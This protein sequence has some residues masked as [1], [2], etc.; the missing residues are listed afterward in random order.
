MSI[1][2]GT[3][4]SPPINPVQDVLQELETEVQDI[5][6]GFE[7]R[8]R[9]LRRAGARVFGQMAPDSDDEEAEEEGVDAEE[10]AL[11]RHPDMAH[12]LPV[13][14]DEAHPDAVPAADVPLVGRG[15]G[16]VEEAFR[17]AEAVLS[18]ESR[19]AAAMEIAAEAEAEAATVKPAHAEL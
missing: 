13:P 16:E 2:N 14:G 18:P 12:I 11:L 5:V 15:K 4:P 6:M 9:Q 7:T 1:Q 19:L 17:R 10:E 8:L 3:H